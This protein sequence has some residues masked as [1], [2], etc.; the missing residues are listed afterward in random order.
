MFMVLGECRGN[1]R[2][3]ANLFSRRFPNQPGKSPMAFHRLQKRF[4]QTGNIKVKRTARN[5]T[6]CNEENTTNILA[7]VNVNPHVSTRSIS[8]ES[9][10]SKSS[11]L[12]ILKTAKYHAYHMSLL[13]DLHG[14]D[15]AN[16]VTFCN[17]ARQKYQEDPLFFNSVMFSDESTFTNTGHVNRHNMHYWAETNPHWMRAVPHQHPWSLNVWCGIVGDHLVGPHFFEG[18]LNGPMY[19]EFIVNNLPQLLENVPLHIRRNMWMQHDGAPPHYAVCSRLEMNN[20]F[21]NKWIGRGGPVAWPARSPDL[22]MVDFF[23]WGFLKQKVMET[24]PTTRDDM[25]ERIRRACELVTPEMLRNVRESFATRVVRC[26]A[27]GGG[28]FEHL[29]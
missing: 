17:W 18:H 5:N 26:I 3:A 14:N 28:H 2:D 24:A 7:F 21:Q 22:T 6:V 10:I 25:R 12:R 13:Q 11:I 16:R 29:I 27:V 15:H 20:V 19:A 23:L 9:G 4:L 8:N 1:F